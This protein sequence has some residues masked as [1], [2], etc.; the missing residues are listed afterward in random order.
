MSWAPPPQ[1]VSFGCLCTGPRS[2]GMQKAEAAD[3]NGK[4]AALASERMRN[5]LQSPKNR[6][7]CVT[8]LSRS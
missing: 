5:L 4:Q 3:L 8:W 1:E 6:S 2:T 7:L